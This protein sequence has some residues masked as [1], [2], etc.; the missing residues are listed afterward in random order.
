MEGEI[1]MTSGNQVDFLKRIQKKVKQG[2]GQGEGANYIPWIKVHHFSSKGR[3]SRIAGWKT[4]RTHHLFSDLETGY[5]YILEW[6]PIARDI[7]EQYPLLPIE[8]TLQIA[9][10]LGIKHPTDFGAKIP[11]VMTTDFLITVPEGLKAMTTKYAQDLES[12]RN[13]EKFEIERV[14]WHRRNVDWGIVTERE[15][16]ETLVENIRIIHKSYDIEDIKPEIINRVKVF[17]ENEIAGSSESLS[18][19]TI[20][21][22]ER[23]GLTNGICL[24]LVYHFI[25]KRLWSIDMFELINPSKPLKIINLDIQSKIHQFGGKR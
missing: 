18:D 19:I 7:R 13:I 6:S 24:N 3:S 9:D 14:Y 23:F 21:T 1:E 16:P 2:Y 5:F 10:E 17:L 12:Y 20:K 22:D 4:R 8:E 11:K 25:A 15:V